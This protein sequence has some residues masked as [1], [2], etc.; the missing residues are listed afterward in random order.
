MTEVVRDEDVLKT[1]KPEAF[2]AQPEGF[3]KLL[4]TI[5]DQQLKSLIE[6]SLL[7]INQK[8][9][10]LVKPLTTAFAQAEK[11]PEELI[12]LKLAIITEIRQRLGI[13]PIETPIET[14]GIATM[15]KT[16]KLP[17]T[18]FKDLRPLEF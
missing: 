17:K 9:K 15:I 11:S 16:C 12:G 2:C 18:E 10:D 7:K 6:Q 4:T 5:K 8:M 13:P 14:L 1:L 3:A